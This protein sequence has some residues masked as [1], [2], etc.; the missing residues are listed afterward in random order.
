M[1][2]RDRLTAEERALQAKRLKE[3]GDKGEEF[4]LSWEKDRLDAMKNPFKPVHRAKMSDSYHFDIESR[5]G[6][7]PIY[8]EVKTTVLR[9]DD[10]LSN[11]FYISSDEYSFYTNNPETYRLYRVYDICL[12]YTSR[13]V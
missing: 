10:V 13:C 4:A 1:C 2:I 12:L 6:D 8:I 11:R 3:I 7:I 5:E 9:K